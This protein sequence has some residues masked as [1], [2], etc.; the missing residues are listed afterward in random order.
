MPTGYR[1]G[2]ISAITVFL[3]FSL[4]FIRFWGF[5]ASGNWTGASRVVVTVILTSLGLQIYTLFRALDI[6]DE[7]PQ[8][9]AMTVRWFLSSVGLL[10]FGIVT[11]MFIYT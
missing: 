2:I 10:T 3:A 6:K 7:D 8:R 9:Y 5:E 11:A 1:Q 4:A